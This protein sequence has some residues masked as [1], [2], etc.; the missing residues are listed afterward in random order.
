MLDNHFYSEWTEVDKIPNT[1]LLP[2]FMKLL[3][4]PYIFDDYTLM[5]SDIIILI[6]DNDLEK[7]LN[8][9]LFFF[10]HVCILASWSYMGGLER[11]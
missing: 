9:C 10:V 11:T 8:F 5:L 2:F 1:G 4:V 6:I 3:Q 7:S